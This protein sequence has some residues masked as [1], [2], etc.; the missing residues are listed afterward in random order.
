MKHA[1]DKNHPIIKYVWEHGEVAGYEINL[2][3]Y[4][5]YTIEDQLRKGVERSLLTRRKAQAKTGPKKIVWFYRVRN[6]IQPD[7]SKEKA[8][9]TYIDNEPDYAYYLRNFFREKP[10]DT[11]G[12]TATE[13]CGPATDD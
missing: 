5:R 1:M 8:E 3:Q 10:N 13:L 2:P 11:A 4:T 7:D 9:I 12:E 6:G